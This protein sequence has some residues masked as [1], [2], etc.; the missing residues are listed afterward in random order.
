MRVVIC[1]K[2]HV[3]R[4]RFISDLIFIT[5]TYSLTIKVS[6]FTTD[7]ARSL[8]QKIEINKMNSDPQSSKNKSSPDEIVSRAEELCLHIEAITLFVTRR[9]L[10]RRV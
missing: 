9:M 10:L 5:S 3:N 1:F 8:A 4:L 7:F 2:F 6:N